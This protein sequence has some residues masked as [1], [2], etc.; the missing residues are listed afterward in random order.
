MTKPG[1]LK[2]KVVRLKKKLA[3]GGEKMT[4]ERSRDVRKQIKRAQRRRRTLVKMEARA[5]K[6]SAK[7]GEEKKEEGTPASA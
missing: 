7:G 1:T 5:A 4:A 2:E 6:K 3:A